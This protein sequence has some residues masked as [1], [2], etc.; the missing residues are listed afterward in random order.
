MIQIRCYPI[1]KASEFMKIS[2]AFNLKKYVDSL[3]IP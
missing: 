3:M 1:K 2:E